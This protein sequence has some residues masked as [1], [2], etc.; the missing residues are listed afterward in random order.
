[1]AKQS[2]FN[3]R[4]R[5]AREKAGLSLQGAVVEA[6]MQLPTARAVWVSPATV[7]RLEI[8]IPEEK[9]NPVTVAV[10]ARVYG[11]ELKK[12][13]PLIAAEVAD[14]RIALSRW[15]ATTTPLAA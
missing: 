3:Q 12:L 13:S 6:C 15:T 2:T 10:L 8:D 11:I 14:L 1:M 4:M 9:A 7:R 5:A